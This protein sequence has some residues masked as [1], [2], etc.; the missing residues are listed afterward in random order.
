M[1]THVERS[2]GARALRPLFAAAFLVTPV[3]ALSVPDARADGEE[4]PKRSWTILAER[5]YTASG[6]VIEGGWVSVV[7][8]KIAAVGPAPNVADGENVLRV[9][10]VTPGLI[11]LSPNIDL[12]FN[13]VEQESEVTPDVRVAHALDPFSRDFARALRSGVTTVLCSPPDE[14]V[15]GGLSV[16]VKTGGA[17]SIAARTVLEDAVLRGSFGTQPSRRNS[18]AFGR[19]RTIYNRR[20][21]TRMGVEWLWRKSFYE[22]HVARQDAQR[23]F[24]GV[25]QLHRVVDGALPLMVQA[26]ATQ[27]IRTAIFLKAEFG[28][29]NLIL[30]HAAE[31]WKEPEL[32][33]RSGASVVLPPYAWNGRTA[34]DRGLHAW[35]TA[36]L[37]EELG[38]TFAL[39]ARNAE[40]V[41][42]RLP[43]QAAYAI[44]G[45][46]SPER[47]L[48][49]VTIDPARMIGIDGRVGSL[50]V[51]KDADIVLWTGEPFRFTSSIAGVMLEGELVVD[52]R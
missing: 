44:R 39:S 48:R 16:A 4:G 5:V 2:F 3:L 29:P 11:D 47:A 50:E 52:P 12:G 51:G 14:N 30:D 33:K 27:D 40:D 28:I 46:L 18:P 43:M 24:P 26:S 36:V 8:G 41:D 21:T 9:A 17:A 31:A 37:L 45:G 34:V 20:P 10:A 1:G 23:A 38:V 19:A 32:L 7:D 6:D 35:N 25:E 49:A 42:E 15:I 22:A 13:S